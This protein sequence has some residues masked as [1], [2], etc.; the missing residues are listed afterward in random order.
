MASIK[1]R[2]ADIC[3]ATGPRPAGSEAEQRAA[4]IIARELEATGASVS[5]E[6]FTVR[7]R[8]LQAL[9]FCSCAGYL[10]YF[11]HYHNPGDDLPAIREEGLQEACELCLQIVQQVEVAGGSAS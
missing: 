5:T 11:D 3:Q 9:L 7:P 2:I 1:Q 6:H 8:A 10:D 4:G